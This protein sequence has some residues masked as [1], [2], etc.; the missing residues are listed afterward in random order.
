MWQNT[1]NYEFDKVEWTGWRTYILGVANLTN[2]NGDARSIGIFFM[3]FDLA[4]NNG[5]EK[6]FSSVLGDILKLD[7]A[8]NVCA[9]H[10]LVLGSCQTLSDSLT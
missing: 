5:V 7:E 9:F 10:A 2:C 3:R 1:D 4:D 6:F 8:E